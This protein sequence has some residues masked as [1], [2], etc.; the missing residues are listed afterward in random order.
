MDK[1]NGNQDAEV[2]DFSTMLSQKIGEED[3]ESKKAASDK[4]LDKANPKK[5]TKGD[6]FFGFDDDE[7]EEEDETDAERIARE[8]AEADEDETPEEKIAREKAEAE[9]E[10]D[11]TEEEK[12]AREK[13]EAEADETPEEKLARE[14][15]ESEAEDDGEEET[16]TSV[17][18]KTSLTAILG[19]SVTHIIQED[20]DGKEV[21][22]AIAD[23]E[24]DQ[25]MYND[26]LVNRLTQ[27]EEEAKK[28]KIDKSKVSD[29]AQRLLDIDQ[30]G[31][32]I[33]DLIKTK[34]NTIDPLDALDLEKPEDQKKAIFMRLKAGEQHSELDI[35]RLIKAYE[36]EGILQATAVTSDAELRTAVEGQTKRA[37][38]KADDDKKTKAGL[39]KRYKTDLRK[40]MDQFELKDSIKDKIVRAATKLGKKGQFEIDDL[41]FN[42]K[43]EP[44]KMAQMALF[45]LDEE[46]FFKQATKDS[47]KDAQVST[48]KTMKLVKKAGAGSTTK[49][50][51]KAKVGLSDKD[52]INFDFLK[53]KSEQ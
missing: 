34:V 12:L 16:E 2:I 49:K 30:N 28:D 5:E 7:D 33:A 40:N 50:N 13:A 21:E 27:V 37:E 43:G 45:M 31:G 38:L 1:N 46:E 44:K 25:E 47:K 19:D 39:M 6:N 36:E 41:Y 11:E 24:M 4:E 26:I 10:G 22:V 42:M 23:L 14:K 20:A 48:A 9:A 15:A 52:E 8:K 29:F 35:K 51:T 18:L 17:A 53:S 32:D 3:D